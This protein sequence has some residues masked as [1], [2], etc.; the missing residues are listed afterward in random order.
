MKATTLYY[1][2]DAINAIWG[3]RELPYSIITEFVKNL[4]EVML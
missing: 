2:S 1:Q 4:L 3:N